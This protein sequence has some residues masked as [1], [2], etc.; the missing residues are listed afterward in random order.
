MFGKIAV[1]E[2]EIYILGSVAL[3]T[4][5]F[6]RHTINYYHGEKRRFKQMKRFAQE[7]DTDAQRYLAQKYHKGEMVKKSC[8]KAAF[9]YQKA[10]F[11]GDE[12]AKGFLEK[13]FENRQKKC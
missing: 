1:E 11:A 4:L 13:F 10:A 8:S 2:I 5:W 3:F 7:G 6:I 9:W 12:E